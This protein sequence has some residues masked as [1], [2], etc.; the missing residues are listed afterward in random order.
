MDTYGH[1]FPGQEADT[2]ARFPNKIDRGPSVLE[3]TGTAGIGKNR[4]QQY[5]QQSRP[6]S[7]R[8][9][10]APRESDNVES[11]ENDGPNVLQL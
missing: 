7:A 3:A 5:P 6:I 1:L 11:V 2:V 10:A 4:T 9:D 8:I